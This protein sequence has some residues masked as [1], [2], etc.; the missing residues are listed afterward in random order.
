[1]EDYKAPEEN[2]ELD[3]EQPEEVSKTDSIEC[4]N[5]KSLDKLVFQ[6]VRVTG[7]NKVKPIEILACKNCGTIFC[8]VDTL[9]G[10]F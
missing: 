3:Q 1:M 2:E 8:D 6:T 9:E 10:I 7:P 5:C 4:P